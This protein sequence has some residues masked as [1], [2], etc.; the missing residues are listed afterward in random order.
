[1]IKGTLRE[2]FIVMN[3]NKNRICELEKVRLI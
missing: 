1:M 3:K 2:R